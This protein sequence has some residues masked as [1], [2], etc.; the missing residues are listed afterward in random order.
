MMGLDEHELHEK[1]V[2]ELHEISDRM[3]RDSRRKHFLERM[4]LLLGNGASAA[5]VRAL[6]R[7]AHLAVKERVR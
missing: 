7:T 5:E 6:M 3:H 1:V 4:R 2:K